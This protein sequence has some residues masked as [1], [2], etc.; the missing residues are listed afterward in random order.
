MTRGGS[1]RGRQTLV[2]LLAASVFLL[3]CAPPEEDALLLGEDGIGPLEL[4]K[5]YEETVAAA[6]QAAPETAFAGLGC[7]GL[8]EVRYSG[9]FAGLPV[10]AMAMA[11]QGAIVEI[12]MTVDAPTQTSREEDCITLRDRFARP[13]VTRFGPVEE[14]WELPKPVSREHLA[15][16]GPVVV[17]ARWFRTGGSCYISAHYGYGAASTTAT[18]E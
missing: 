8:D 15:R 10:S 18:W 5:S 13:F 4:G 3:G 2:A 7:G 16:I 11:E 12:E 14:H 9:Q 17:V 6:R 1:P